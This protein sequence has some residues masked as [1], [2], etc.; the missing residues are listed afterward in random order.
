MGGRF[1]PYS[2][3]LFF[4][5]GAHFVGMGL[6][7][8]YIGRIYRDVRGKATLFCRESRAQWHHGKRRVSKNEKTKAS[9]VEP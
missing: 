4:F 9:Q 5:I 1:S 6:L 2:P 7:G 3:F 8:E